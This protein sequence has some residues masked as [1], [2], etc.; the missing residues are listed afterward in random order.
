MQS[1]LRHSLPPATYHL[2]AFDHQ[3]NILGVYNTKTTALEQT[4][5]YYPYGLPHATPSL[6]TATNRRLYSAKELTT[7][8]ALNTYDFAARWQSPA[9]PHFTTPDPLAEDYLPIGTN[10]FCGGDPINKVDPTGMDI[11]NLN[12]NGLI[13][14][15]I[16][17]DEYDEIN[18]VDDNG[19]VLPDQSIRFEAGTISV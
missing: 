5:D 18:F 11:Y 15:Y 7:E 19:D 13:V 6:S 4:T 14:S 3:G 10:V 17:N 9:F 2:Y 16:A 12:S 1:N 8:A